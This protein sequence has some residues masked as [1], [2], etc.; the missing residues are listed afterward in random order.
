MIFALRIHVYVEMAASHNSEHTRENI[1]IVSIKT[2]KVLV[3]IA[4]IFHI[5]GLYCVTVAHQLRVNN[6]TLK[7]LYQQTY[8]SK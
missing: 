6:K 1:C 3:V 8:L 7:V 4:F 2:M 5:K